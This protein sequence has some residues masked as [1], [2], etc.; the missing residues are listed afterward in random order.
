MIRDLFDKFLID[1]EKGKNGNASAARRARKISNE[2]TKEL[3]EFRK[4]SL[5]WD[6][7]K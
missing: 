4:E 5:T 7:H 3:K 2:I 1:Y 6:F